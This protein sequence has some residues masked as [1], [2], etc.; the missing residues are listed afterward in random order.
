[1]A[2]K[3]T[4]QEFIEKARLQHGDRYDYNKV[5]YINS[6]TKIIIT[7]PEHGDFEQEP[8]KHLEGRGCPKCFKGDTKK[9]IELANKI[10]N[11]KY[12]YS[13]TNYKGRHEKLII[14][15][16]IHGDFEQEA[17][18][19]L[20]GH[21]CKKC[22]QQ[23]SSEKQRLSQ[24]EF[25][26]KCN[27]IHNGKYNYSKVKYQNYKTEVIITCPEHG[28]FEQRPDVHLQ[29]CGCPK[30]AGVYKYTTEEFIEK[31]RKIHGD[32]YDYSKV[33]YNNAHEEVCII[34]PEHKEFWQTPNGHLNGCGCPK[35]N[36]SHGETFIENYLIENNIKFIDQYSI[37]IDKS[38]NK[39]GKASIDFYL[40]DLNIAIEYNG[41]QHYEYIPYFHTGGIIDFKRQ[42]KRD[43]YVR[44]YCKNNNI[45]LIE[46]KYDENLN[47]YFDKI[48]W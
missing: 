9:F 21:G 42:Q 23:I 13:K 16:P 28:D 33:E 26:E 14:T 25:I 29:G 47:N 39:T 20:S 43:E 45:R 36:K 35:C 1:M 10:H 38:I 31:A 40:P 37:D 18:S 44:N 34:C 30:C 46:I 32:K 27:K 22:A 5:E 3:L 17:G 48:Q 24:N 4:K 8:R 11:N 12:N 15:C 7:C 2:K 19:H 6:R 41:K